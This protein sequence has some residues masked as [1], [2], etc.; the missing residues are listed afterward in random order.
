MRLWNGMVCC[1]LML[2]QILCGTSLRTAATDAS[3]IDRTKTGSVQLTLE[4][5]D[6]EPVSDGVISIYEVAVLSDDGYTKTE[7]FGNF[8]AELDVEDTALA[9][10][11]VVYVESNQIDGTRRVID[12][13]GIAS[14]DGL[15]LGLY[16]I[17]QTEESADYETI[18]PFLVTIPIEEDGVWVYDVDVT[19]KVGT[20]TA[21]A[22]ESEES[23]SVVTTQSGSQSSASKSVAS[24]PSPSTSETLSQT[25]Q[26]NWPIP[27][28]TIG[29]V[30]LFAVGW[31]L[32]H[33]KPKQLKT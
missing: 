28:L 19:P 23:S 1:G 8:T 2:L 11:L 12:E 29:G 22:T 24:T 30:L 18:A 10:D 31:I 32:W 25:G 26:L 20:V 5:D 15:E 9:S 17:V 3:F 13:V 14:F 7:A 27:I 4:T 16:L 33:T 21:T 6:G